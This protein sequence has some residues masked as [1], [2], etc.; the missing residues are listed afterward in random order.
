MAEE[1]TGFANA[2]VDKKGK[3]LD[4][5]SVDAY[6]DETEAGKAR[7]ASQSTP[8]SLVQFHTEDKSTD[9]APAAVVPAPVGEDKTGTDGD[10]DESTAQDSNPTTAQTAG[11]KGASGS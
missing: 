8:S 4:F 5:R 2:P 9:G 7:D 6:V 1:F 11:G 10:S 3:R